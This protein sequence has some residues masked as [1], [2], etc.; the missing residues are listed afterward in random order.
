MS[1]RS[2]GFILFALSIVLLPPAGCYRIDMYAPHGMDVTLASSK[3]PLEV[4]R[5]WR[6]WFVVWGVTPLDNNMP[7][8][9]IAREQLTEV[10]VITTDTVPDALLGVLYNVL[11]PIGLANQSI[12]I[13]GNRPTTA[14][15]TTAAT[16]RPAVQ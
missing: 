6:T 7:D 8:T 16:T 12:V 15:A 13:E 11:I 2:Q 9:Q 10:R 4:Q 14:A 5:H 3:Q 1:A